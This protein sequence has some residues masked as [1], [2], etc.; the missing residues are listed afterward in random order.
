[1]VKAVRPNI[2]HRNKRRASGAKVFQMRTGG[3][4]LPQNSKNERPN[5]ARPAFNSL[6][7]VHPCGV[8]AFRIASS[9]FQNALC[10]ILV[11]SPYGGG[12]YSK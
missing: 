3:Q 5:A 2:R 9:Y 11:F 8:A 10:A 12:P 1:M 4:V 7:F 6:S